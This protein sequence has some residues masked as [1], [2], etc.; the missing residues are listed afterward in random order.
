MRKNNNY[1]G[2][3]NTTNNKNKKILN[4]LGSLKESKSK[5]SK[6]KDEEEFKNDETLKKNDI[7]KKKL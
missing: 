6:I 4:K 1:V 3:K 7:L 5:L 2:N